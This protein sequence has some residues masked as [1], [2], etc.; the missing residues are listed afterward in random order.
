LLTSGIEKAEAQGISVG[1]EASVKGLGLY[2]KMGF[3]EV[4]VWS[5][6]KFKIPVLKL[7]AS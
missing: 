6:A 5:I 3:T 1:T 7:V 2:K 4:G